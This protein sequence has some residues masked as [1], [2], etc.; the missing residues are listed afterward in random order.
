MLHTS[1]RAYFIVIHVHIYNKAVLWP[2]LILGA[3]ITVR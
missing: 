3:C 2:C 1:D